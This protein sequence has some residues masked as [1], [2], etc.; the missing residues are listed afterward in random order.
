NFSRRKLI[1]FEE[2]HI[3]GPN[4]VNTARVG[5]SRVVANAP[6]TVSILNPILNDLSLGFLPGQPIGILSIT[7]LQRF[8]G[9]NGQSSD[10]FLNSYQDYD[11]LF[12]T[13]GN[14]ALKFG[15]AIE[16]AQLNEFTT[17]TPNGGWNYGSLRNFLTNGAP[18]SF[19]TTIPGTNANPTYLRQMIFG[20]YVQAD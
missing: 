16:R 13:R 12:Y 7:G 1:T 20:L 18:T 17:S 6:K 8:Q 9:V 15:V 14:H 2:T 3:F 11:D 5:Y 19:V 10:F 4:L